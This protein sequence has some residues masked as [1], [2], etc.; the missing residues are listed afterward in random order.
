MAVYTPVDRQA[1]A[2]LLR[3]YRVGGLLGF[4]GIEAGIE[5]TNYFVDTSTG[6]YV[7]TLFEI[8]DPPQLAV[9]LALLEF[10]AG[11]GVPCARPVPDRRGRLLQSFL[12]RPAA[13]VERL[14]GASVNAPSRAHC[15]EVGRAL[16]ALHR[17]GRGYP[18]VVPDIRGRAWH[19]SVAERLLGVLPAGEAALLRAE[20]CTLSPLE[21]SPLPAGVIHADLFRDNVLFEGGRLSG[22]LDFYYA[23][24]GPL[25]YDL[26]V[27]A[28]A[29]CAR[30]DGGLDEARL[31]ALAG[32][33][34]AARP[35]QRDEVG[36]WPT[37]LCAAALRYWLSRAHDRRFPRRGA[38]GAVKDPAPLRRMLLHRREHAAALR[39][40]LER[41]VAGGVR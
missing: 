24:T 37:M 17:A 19:R 11:R 9:F 14:P 33:Y 23:F 40:M 28:N 2:A 38:L 12:A 39:S 15:R 29:W 13:L 22:I 41:A 3:R 16:A 32:A 21:A 7:L 6:R 1:L 10:L 25:L 34:A 8:I 27:T 5:N 18:G 26:A 30:A 31:Q 36:A 4:E 20:L 35:L